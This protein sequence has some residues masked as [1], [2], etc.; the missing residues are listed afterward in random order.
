[1]LPAAMEVNVRAARA[2]QPEG[3]FLRRCDEIGRI[4]TGRPEA[5]A[6][7]GVAWIRELC[8]ALSVRPLRAY[9][10]S[11]AEIPALVER[12]KATSS[13]KGNPVP[14]TDEEI[15]EIVLRSL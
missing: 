11:E 14:L 6:E 4:L 9:G 1:M 2:R 7:D 12:S 5:H 15:A 10:V 3:E 8:A 13:M